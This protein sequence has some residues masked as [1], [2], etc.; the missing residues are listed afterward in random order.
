MKTINNE[1]KLSKSPSILS[2]KVDDEIILLSIKGSEYLGLNDIATRIW[3]ILDKEIS[4][5][6]L[7]DT[8]TSEYDIDAETCERET[9][10]LIDS[11]CT[12]ELIILK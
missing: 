1:T 5:G 8:L 6:Q 2:S 7:I 4:L 9:M 12:E 11:L 3:E 10:E